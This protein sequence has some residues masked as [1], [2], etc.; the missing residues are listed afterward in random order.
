FARDAATVQLQNQIQPGS[1]VRTEPAQLR[2]IL[3][4]LISNAIK[5]HDP[6]KVNPYIRL[7]SLPGAGYI[8]IFVEDNGIGIAAEHLN[9]I[10]DAHYTIAA[11]SEQSKGLG[12]AN[13]KHAVE[14][15]GGTISV[16]S[17]PGSGSTFNLRLPQ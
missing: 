6:H 14:K 3:A 8:E 4:N 11:S 16:Q 5:Y 17:V 13:V 10:F 15:L 12:L 9:R 1:I 7:R 2:I